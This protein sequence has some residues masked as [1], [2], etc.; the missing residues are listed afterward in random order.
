MKRYAIL[1]LLLSTCFSAFTQKKQDYA[2]AYKNDVIVDGRLEEWS[3]L[4]NVDEKGAWYYQLLHDDTNLYI[5][6]RIQDATLQGR[7][8]K[9]GVLIQFL[10]GNKKKKDSSFSYPYLDN[11]VRRA[12]N[13]AFLEDPLAAAKINNLALIQRSRGIKVDGFPQLVDGLLAEQ[14]NYGLRVVIGVDDQAM[15]YE[16][17]IPKRLLNINVDEL[18]VGLQI[19]GAT[20]IGQG[21]K[22]KQSAGATAVRLQARLIAK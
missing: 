5:A 12:L 18:A 2:I 19:N 17:A 11:E 7:V 10:T 6:V 16:A 15:Y 3:D 1:F 9:D 20:A 22:N 21:K 14:N 8:A 13:Q 4:T